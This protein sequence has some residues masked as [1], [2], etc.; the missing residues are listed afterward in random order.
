MIAEL[1]F[2]VGAIATAVCFARGF[3]G[4]GLVGVASGLVMIVV[5]FFVGPALE[6]GLPALLIGFVYAAGMV[7]VVLARPSAGVAEG[8]PHSG[9]RQFRR[10]LIG[11]VIGFVPGALLVAIPILLHELDVITA[12]QSQIGFLGIF[13]TPVGVIA[14]VL[15]GAMTTSQRPEERTKADSR[16]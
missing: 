15:I 14:G 16:S 13:L 12:D 3:R 4:A 10:G 5:F 2:I 8:A 1:L 9:S 7:A 11:G 6:S